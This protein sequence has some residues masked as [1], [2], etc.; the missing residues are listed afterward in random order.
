MSEAP[1]DPV[2]CPVCFVVLKPE[3]LHA[4]HQGS[5]EALERLRLQHERELETRSREAEARL[6][7]AEGRR[8]KEME[9]LEREQKEALERLRQQGEQ[10]LAHLKAQM[11]EIQKTQFVAL[12]ESHRRNLEQL[13]KEVAEAQVRQKGWAEE[14]QRLQQE[15]S[16]REK[17]VL[18]RAKIDAGQELSKKEQ[19]IQ[20]LMLNENRLREQVD[21]LRES[22]L[23]SPSDV[24]GEAGEFLLR[25]TLRT[26]FPDDDVQKISRPGQRS[27][28][29][30]HRISRAPGLYTPTVIVYDNKVGK[31]VTSKDL[32]SARTYREVHGTDYVL[33]VTDEM[34]SGSS[35]RLVVEEDG[36]LIVKRNALIALVEVLRRQIVKLDLAR[37]SGA[38]RDRKESQLFDY[39]RGDEFDRNLKRL[40]Q[41]D[42]KEHDLL[43][44]EKRSHLKM[45]KQREDIHREREE[46][47]SQVESSTSAI[48]ERDSLTSNP[49]LDPPQQVEIRAEV[50]PSPDSEEA[51]PDPSEN[52]E[53]REPSPMV[54]DEDGPL[55]RRRKVQ[56]TLDGQGN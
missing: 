15:F 31:K 49:E 38:H 50:D 36:I 43:E 37:A 40:L 42:L 24:V 20:Q 3:E 48:L 10:G 34:P 47:V 12:E 30:V 1:G 51:D 32:S 44:T 4:L 5:A 9:R 18:E 14:R 54:G 13:Q 19:Q 26:A 35:E 28:D 11:A 22:V 21:Q 56:V 29:V 52:G 6:Q 46:A 33:V 27:A 17:D 7:E 45:W 23:R 8:K 55:R 16:Q 41:L 39:I 53:E 25:E 2:R